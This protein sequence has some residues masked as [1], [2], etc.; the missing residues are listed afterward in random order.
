M[1]VLFLRARPVPPAKIQEIA[2]SSSGP[3]LALGEAV[4]TTGPFVAGIASSRIA[5]GAGVF[6]KSQAK[7][8]DAANA[9]DGSS[10]FQQMLSTAAPDAVTNNSS[11]QKQNQSDSGKPSSKDAKSD[12]KSDDGTSGLKSQVA[13]ATVSSTLVQVAANDDDGDPGKGGTSDASA[14]GKIADQTAATTS[15]VPPTSQDGTAEQTSQSDNK[16]KDAAVSLASQVQKTPDAS[17][18]QDTLAAND[19]GTSAVS[20]GSAT[21]TSDKGQTAKTKPVTG[22]NVP[23]AELQAQD[24]MAQAVNT[25]PSPTISP[26]A[27]KDHKSGK[28]GVQDTAKLSPDQPAQDDSAAVTLASLAPVPAATA[29]SDTAA[30]DTADSIAAAASTGAAKDAAK[31]AQ[32]SSAPTPQAAPQ[33]A[34]GQSGAANPASGPQ[35]N[36]AQAN[37]TQ[38]NGV[39]ANGSSANGAQTN[40][41]QISG[42]QTSSGSDASQQA[43]SSQNA[44]ATQGSDFQSVIAADIK[45]NKQTADTQTANAQ[46]QAQQPQTAPQPVVPMVQAPAQPQT[47][48]SG[49]GGVSQNV[50]VSAQDSSSTANTV[51]TLAV[52][53]AAK[54]QSG[55]K[56][57]DIRLDPPE[58]GRVEV[59][60]SID[61]SGK[62][63]ASLS[64][65]QPHTLDLLKNDAPALTRALRDAG[66][67]VAQNG[68]NFSL[69]GQNQQ[70][71]GNNGGFTPRGG[72]TAQTSLTATSAIGT[73]Q[74][75][76]NYQGAADGRLDIRV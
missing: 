33:T 6:H 64:A 49:P 59:R 4:S 43:S 3:S 24:T 67:N 32:A 62:A 41:A 54:S 66:L 19:T 44:D 11:A 42:A 38:A 71:G 72:R 15:L 48:T 63:Q 9:A 27:K 50:Q 17:T 68:L 58:L 28:D 16:G 18:L 30:S 57:F 34:S 22:N 31:N 46:P 37:T 20:D 45:D 76:A 23:A 21:D 55:N 69:R 13:T 25:Q 70:S 61:A 40:G 2:G 47:H 29:D 52:A 10:S 60:L 14:N 1:P 65:D 73:V 51:G 5:S 74:G 8:A 56:Q 12:K 7:D 36:T 26:G 39:Q 75:G 35:A 53:I